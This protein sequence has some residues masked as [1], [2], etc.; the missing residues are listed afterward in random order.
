MVTVHNHKMFSFGAALISLT[1]SE[2]HLPLAECSIVLLISSN[3]N[4]SLPQ[5][6]VAILSYPIC[7]GTNGI[8]LKSTYSSIL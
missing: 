3:D 8:L 7:I 1:Q 2:D 6:N 5:L 4:H